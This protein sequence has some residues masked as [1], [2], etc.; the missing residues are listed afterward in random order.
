MWSWSLEVI[1]GRCGEDRDTNERWTTGGRERER[2][3]G[4]ER[5]RE[6]EM[7]KRV[8]LLE[9]CPHFRVIFSYT[10]IQESMGFNLTVTVTCSRVRRSTGNSS[11]VTRQHNETQ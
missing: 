11:L 1:L 7:G 6:R 5:G 3:G 8:T 2:G 9:R 4:R 10:H